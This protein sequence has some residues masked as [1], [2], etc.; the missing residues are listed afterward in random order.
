M[1]TGFGKLGTSTG[2]EFG[3]GDTGTGNGTGWEKTGLELGTGNQY[4]E[5]GTGICISMS[6]LLGFRPFSMEYHELETDCIASLV[7]GAH[8]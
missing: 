1:R 8:S 2:K 6:K 5:D 3:P 4:V 7:N